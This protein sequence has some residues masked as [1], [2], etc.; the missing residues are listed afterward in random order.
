MRSV[1]VGRVRQIKGGRRRR[2]ARKVYG[3]YSAYGAC[4]SPCW[5]SQENSF[6]VVTEYLPAGV[7]RVTK[8]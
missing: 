3:I 5:G 8:R 7:T 6:R 1:S 2:R 4:C